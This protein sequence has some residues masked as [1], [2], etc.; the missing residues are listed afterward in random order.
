MPIDRASTNKSATQRR[1]KAE[2]AVDYSGCP[3]NVERYQLA[4]SSLGR[5]LNLAGVYG[6]RPGC[7]ARRQFRYR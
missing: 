3:I 7:D 5:R 6:L 4:L 1:R 2:F